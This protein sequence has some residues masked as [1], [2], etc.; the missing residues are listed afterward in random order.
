MA[1]FVFIADRRLGKVLYKFCIRVP[2]DSSDSREVRAMR[3]QS[4]ASQGVFEKYGRKS[5]RELFLDVKERVVPWLALGTLVDADAPALREN[6]P[7]A[8]AHGGNEW[9]LMGKGAGCLADCNPAY[10]QWDER[11]A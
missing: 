6:G 1:F 10:S 8:T 11:R 9:Q 4:R 2:I 3:R 7:W 5:G